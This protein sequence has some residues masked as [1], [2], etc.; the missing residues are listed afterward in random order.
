RLHER[1]VYERVGEGW[2]TKR[3]FP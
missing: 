2:E 1:L 3:L